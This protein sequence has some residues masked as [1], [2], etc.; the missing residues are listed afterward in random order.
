MKY[1]IKC[2]VHWRGDARVL[3]KYLAALTK[4]IGG[5]MKNLSLQLKS[6]LVLVI[7]ALSLVTMLASCAM[8]TGDDHETKFHFLRHAEIDSS[9]PDKFLSEQG[10][11]RAQVLVEHFQGKAISQIYATHTDR[12]YNTVSALAKAR[13]IVIRQVPRQGQII[14]GKT[15]TNRSSGKIAINPMIESLKQVEQGSTIIVSANSGNLFAI[16]SGIG[17]PV[18]GEAAC[19]DSDNCLPCKSKKCFPT[20]E[21]NN[22]WTVSVSSDGKISL[23]DSKYG[24]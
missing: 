13:E 4:P 8:F 10:K 23:Q 11:Q 1:P 17:V 12:T 9:T 3:K 2:P 7:G 15:V 18:K 22:I 6:R 24:G 16:M 14:G 20:K 21:F 5:T 19:T